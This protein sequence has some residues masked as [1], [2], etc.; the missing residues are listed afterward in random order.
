MADD[1]KESKPPEPPEKREPTKNLPAKATAT[2]PAPAKPARKPLPPWKVL[3]HNDDEN[4][5][6]HVIETIVMLTTLNEQEANLR[7]NEA[8][9]Q[10]L[11]LLLTTHRE[12]AELYQ[13]QFASRNLTVTIEQAE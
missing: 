10:G 11:S 12:R 2:R 7:A 3:L 6:G 13:Q 8:H 9:R 5:F 4:D 1:K